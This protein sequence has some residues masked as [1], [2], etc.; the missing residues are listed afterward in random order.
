MVDDNYRL[1]NII[2]DLSDFEGSGTELVSVYVPPNRNVSDIVNHLNSEVSEAS[3]IKSKN[4]RN[5]VQSALKSL[6]SK[7]SN[8]DSIPDNGLVMFSGV[9]DN[10]KETF[11]IDDLPKEITS[12]RYHC[13]SEFL[14]DPLEDI[15]KSDDVYGLLSL[16]LNACKLGFL[17][18]SRIVEKWHYEP[19]IH[20]KH[21]AGGQSQARFDRVREKQ[22]NQYFNKVADACKSIFYDERHDINGF[23]IG[24][25]SH[26]V[27]KFLDS[28]KLHHEI[29]S[30]IIGKVSVSNT[31]ER[32]LEELINNS[33]N[34]LEDAEYNHYKELMSEFFTGLRNSNSEYGFD[35]VYN[36]LEIGAVEKILVSE[37]ISG[38]VSEYSNELGSDEDV[39]TFFE[40]E[41]KKTGASFEVI[42]YDFEK[43]EQF[44][45]SLTGF[46]AILRYNPYSN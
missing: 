28:N 12:F 25:T 8:Y 19:N 16:D 26:T 23:I 45:D 40:R 5:N 29:E 9:I 35:E 13:G 3:S 7:I 10:N 21:S 17:R 34:I 20:S 24:G 11:I 38:S 36:L 32:G 15:V 4:T 6:S 27:D 33:Q 1:N 43:G 39:Y 18:G 37:K 42:P 46:G 44:Y 14:L 41:S 2:S 22:I 30:N 31:E